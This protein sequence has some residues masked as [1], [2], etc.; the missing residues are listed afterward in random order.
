MKTNVQEPWGNQLRGASMSLRSDQS[1]YALGQ[2]IRLTMH[3]RNHSRQDIRLLSTDIVTTYRLLAF[4][5][6]GH[7]MEKSDELKRAEESSEP[8]GVISRSLTILKPDEETTESFDAD[9]LVKVQQPG[10][11]YMVVIR[12]LMSWD[13]GFLVSNAIHVEIVRP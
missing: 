10:V 1:K 11:Y 4:D 6:H 7:P 9:R 13:E 5:T 12:R 3:I 8:P 2:P